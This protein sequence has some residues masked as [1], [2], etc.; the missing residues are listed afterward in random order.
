MMSLPQIMNQM[1]PAVSNRIIVRMIP[2]MILRFLDI[3]FF[4]FFGFLD[5]LDCLDSSD[6][7]LENGSGS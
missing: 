3:F 2:K 7:S 1:Q 6:S 5:F 4:A